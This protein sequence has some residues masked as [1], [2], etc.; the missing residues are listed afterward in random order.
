MLSI[1]SRVR[2]HRSILPVML[3]ARVHGSIQWSCPACQ[4]LNR[5]TLHYRNGFRVR[6]PGSD[7]QRTFAVG[8]TF[9]S[10]T[11]GSKIP[12]PDSIMPVH[13]SSERWHSGD[14]V[15]R[16]ITDSG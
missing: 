8:L 15:N 3:F 16:I 1:D 5:S 12:P 2:I 10:I 7:C 4:R 9:Y 6:C 11:T 13:V 14:P